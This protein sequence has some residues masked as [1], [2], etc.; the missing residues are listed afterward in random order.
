MQTYFPKSMAT[1]VLLPFEPGDTVHAFVI[2][3]TGILL[4]G[5]HALD[6]PVTIDDPRGLN[7]GACPSDVVDPLP[8][9]GYDR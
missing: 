5:G 8:Q 2:P 6:F 3:H 4:L 9:A 1:E 7:N